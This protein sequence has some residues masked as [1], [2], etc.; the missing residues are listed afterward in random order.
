MK[1]NAFTII[2]LIFV[3]FILGV[4]A[5]VAVVKMGGMSD[6]AKEVQLKAFTGTLNRTSGA[7]FWFKSIED[8]LDGNVSNPAYDLVIDQYIEIVPGYSTGPSLVN[9]N[10]AGT[11]IFL[12]Y[13]F[14][15]TYEIHCKNGSMSE[16]PRFRLYIVDEGIYLD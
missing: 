16:S 5:A 13:P 3:I 2:E 14:T 4:L 9:C 6:R 11:G 10:T 15:Q 1:R 12:T 8:G 7:G